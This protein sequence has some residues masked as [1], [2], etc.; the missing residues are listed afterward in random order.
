VRESRQAFNRGIGK[1]LRLAGTGEE[2]LHLF[3]AR[4]LR[5]LFCG[6]S[7]QLHASFCRRINPRLGVHASGYEQRRYHFLL[8]FK[9]L[10]TTKLGS[11]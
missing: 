5:E 2:K 9:G 10:F 8:L 11:V 3:G 1:D 7:F 4:E 6:H